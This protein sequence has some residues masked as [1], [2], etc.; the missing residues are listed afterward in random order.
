[1]SLLL[2][3]SFVVVAAFPPHNRTVLNPEFRRAEGDIILED[4]DLEMIRGKRGAPD[5]SRTKWPID[6]VI[7]YKLEGPYDSA[8]AQMI[9]NG[10]KFWTDNSCLTYQETTSTTPNILVKKGTDCSST[11][12]RSSAASHIINFGEG[13]NNV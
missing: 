6:Q 5:T 3:L 11:L 9:R 12:G 10:F 2:L 1:T 4:E 13:C 8:Y 7:S